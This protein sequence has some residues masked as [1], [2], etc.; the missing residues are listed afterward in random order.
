MTD[1]TLRFTLTSEASL[2]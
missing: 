2:V 1:S